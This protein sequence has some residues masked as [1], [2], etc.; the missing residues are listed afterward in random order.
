MTALIPLKI[1][2]PFGSGRSARWFLS[3][4][5][6]RPLQ[7]SHGH[8]SHPISARRCPVNCRYALTEDECYKLQLVRDSMRLVTILLDEVQHSN[9]M[10][11]QMMA[12]W[13]ELTAESLSGVADAAGQRL[14]AR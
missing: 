9:T 14:T 7:P 5:Q 8:R 3:C 12:A 10:T 4:F 13:L 2:P 11:P 6:T 1:R